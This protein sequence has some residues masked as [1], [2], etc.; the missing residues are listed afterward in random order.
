MTKHIFLLYFE[1]FIQFTQY[2]PSQVGWIV[3]NIIHLIHF[4]KKYMQDYAQ[5]KSDMRLQFLKVFI[6]YFDLIGGIKLPKFY[7]TH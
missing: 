2:I 1:E 3:N 4:F 6:F 5:L 7:S